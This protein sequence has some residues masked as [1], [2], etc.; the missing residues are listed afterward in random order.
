MMLL[1]VKR[2]EAAARLYRKG[3]ARVLWINGVLYSGGSLF[4]FC[5]AL[6]YFLDRGAPFRVIDL[7]RVLAYLVLSVTA[8][9]LYGR[10]T[11][12]NLTRAFSRSPNISPDP[13]VSS[14]PKVSRGPG[15]PVQ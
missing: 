8:G 12:C 2:L 7:T 13:N 14:N 11:W 6:D 5:N 4:V 1:S 10:L 9:Y 15:K 3:R